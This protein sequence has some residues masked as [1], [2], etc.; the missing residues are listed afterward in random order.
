[1]Q[2]LE[3]WVGSRLD[4][5]KPQ[6]GA[7]KQGRVSNPVNETATP[8]ATTATA[9]RRSLAAPFLAGADLTISDRSKY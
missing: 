7:G 1:M 8:L 5:P 3:G 2:K 9:A 6:I 4:A